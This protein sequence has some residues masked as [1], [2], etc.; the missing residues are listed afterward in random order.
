MP[1]KSD[2]STDASRRSFL[3]YA[4]VSAVTLGL[5]GCGGN[6]DG[7]TTTTE[8][9]GD[10]TTEPT[11][12][13]TTTEPSGGTT[14]AGPQVDEV[15]LG[16]NHPLSGFLASTGTG[17]DNALKLA[18]QRKNDEGGIQSLG[19]AQVRVVS[20]D[21]QGEQALGGQVSQQLIEDGADVLLGCFSSP[22][23]T[24]ATAVAERQQVPFVVSVAADDGVLQN[25]G[26][27]WVY[28]PQPPAKRM[29]RD[30]ADLVPEVIR[31]NGGTIETAGLF[32]VNNSYGQAIKKHLQ[33]F[34]PQ[35]DVTVVAE[36]A[37][38]FGASSAD[39][40][41]TKLRQ[42]DPDTI[43]ATTYAPGG[44]TLA[45]SLQN[46]N[47]RPDYLTGCAS[48]TFTDEGAIADVGEFANGVMDNNYA[49]NPTIDKTAQVKE[50]FTN[51]YDQEFSASVGMAYTA[52]EVAIAAI[53][54]AG[55][56]E[57]TAINQ[58]LQNLTYEDHI[59]AMGPI[60]FAANGENTNALAPVNQVQDMKVRVVYPEE[61]AE[62]SPQ[63]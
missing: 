28:R 26:F 7:D 50:Q 23:T 24:A 30:Y 40:Q 18:A 9:A 21:N 31:N 46:Q 60:S 49:L 27:N 25:R 1:R 19:G 45:K 14:T 11:G 22:V 38:S 52:A 16:S 8:P 17:M 48:A 20:G 2:P 37:L 61:F 32:Y 63:I 41:V 6:G 44:V 39:T 58:A 10:D 53:E 59:A 5:A 43:I 35:E 51:R 12:G 13:D 34:L 57:N 29:A 56:V 55:S 47:Y 3:K 42:A 4:G 54:D 62:A 36:T 33:R 15:V